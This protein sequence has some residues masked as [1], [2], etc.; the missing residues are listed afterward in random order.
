MYVPR[1]VQ[2]SIYSLVQTIIC[3]CVLDKNNTIEILQWFEDE[4]NTT[5]DGTPEDKVCNMRTLFAR[6]TANCVQ[7]RK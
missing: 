4:E 6:P 3:R 1:C 7:P 5:A 2:Y